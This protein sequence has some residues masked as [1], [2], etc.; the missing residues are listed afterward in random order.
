MG[1]ARLTNFPSEIANSMVSS[2]TVFSIIF[3]MNGTGRLFRK[4]WKFRVVDL[5]ALV[6]AVAE[7]RCPIAYLQ[8]NDTAIG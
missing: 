6:K 3:P 1:S 8:A 4:S 2:A 7:K 5:N